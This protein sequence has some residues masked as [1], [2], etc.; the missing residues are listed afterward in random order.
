MTLGRTTL[1][2]WRAY[3]DGYDMSGYSRS[4][5]DLGCTFEEG[6]DDALTLRLRQTLLNSA[7]VSMGALNGLFDNTATSGLHVVMNG[8]GVERN[9]MIA[10]GIQAE[11]AAGD[12]VFCGQF[13]QL[14]YHGNPDNNPAHA[15]IPFG[16][17]S[18][19]AG[20]TYAEPWGILLHE[21]AEVTDVNAANGLGGLGQTVNGG[22]MMYHVFDAEGTGA[23]TA[24]LK[25]QHSAT[26]GG[27]YTDLLTTGTLNLGSGDT[28]SGPTSGVV[29]LA[30]TA[31]VASY[32]RWQIVLTLAT[33]VTFT[34]GFFRNWK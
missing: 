27:V 3:I 11:P 31:T 18:V 2:W 7:S 33:S 17:M 22:Y 25:V 16:N 5:G 10:A 26:A 34:L 19:G 9:V 4:F 1:N 32:T 14:A 30:K 29:E 28:F 24:E 6:T 23:I 20:I 13:T 15:T 12:P 8:A 21:K